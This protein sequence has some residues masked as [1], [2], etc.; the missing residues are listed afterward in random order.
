MRRFLVIGCIA[1]ALFIVLVFFFSSRGGLSR[2]LVP[3]I[4]DKQQGSIVATGNIEA[5][6]DVVLAF[7]GNGVVADVLYDTGDTVDA[8]D[9]IAKLEAGTL[10][11]DVEAQRL[12]VQKEQVRLQSFVGGPEEKDRARIDAGVLVAQQQIESSTQVALASAQQIAGEVETIV[13]TE[14]DTLFENTLTDPQLT[15]KHASAVDRKSSSQ[16][17]GGFETLFSKWRLWSRVGD[18]PYEQAISTLRQF[19]ADLRETHRGIV[20][21]YDILLRTRTLSEQNDRDFLL[22][23]SV[24]TT[25]LKHIVSV[26]RHTRDVAVAHA[27]YKLAQAKSDR[28]LAGGTEADRLAQTAQVNVEREKLRRLE[29]QLAKTQIRAPFTGMVGEVFVQVGEFVSSGSDAVRLASDGGFD[30]SVNVTEVDVQ[31]VTVGQQMNARVGATDEELVIIVRTVSGTENTIDDVPVYAVTFD[32]T[33]EE[34]S[35]LPGMTVD[36]YVPSGRS[37][38]SFTIPR[39][40]VQSSRT[41]NEVSVERNGS[42]VSVP[43]IVGLPVGDGM[44]SVTGDLFESDLVIVTE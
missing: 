7:E 38:H 15:S 25:L 28:D 22:V 11:A 26:S 21:L 27:E 43:V 41:G 33:D 6:D 10:L 37:V 19:E 8:G 18:M 12:R 35:L 4:A 17:R 16:I 13:R 32:I 2:T 34:V 23:A 31:A 20:V 24:R 40:A 14:I 44:V 36:V 1:V 39:A 30:L 5:R 42:I 29:L 9:L 3:V